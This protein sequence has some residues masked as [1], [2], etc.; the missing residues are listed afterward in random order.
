MK[1]KAFSLI[2]VLLSIALMAIFSGAIFSLFYASSFSVQSKIN[3]EEAI[4]Y[5]KE[6]L[7]IV[8]SFSYDNYLNLVSGTYV[9]EKDA[10][11]NYFLVTPGTEVLDSFYERQVV[12]SDVY[13]N[14]NGNIDPL[15]QTL[16]PLTKK[17]TI[18]LSWTAN[19]GEANKDVVLQEYITD[20]SGTSWTQTTQS[21]FN[22]GVLSDVEILPSGVIIPDDG[23]A[24]LFKTATNLDY[25]GSANVWS[26]SNDV[27]YANDILYAAV[28]RF[29]G[30]I[31]ATD[32]SDPENPVVLDCENIFGRGQALLV[33]GNYAYLAKNFFHGLAVIDISDPNNLHEVTTISVGGPAKGIDIQGNYLYLS[34]ANSH[35]PLVVVNISNPE[36]PFVASTSG[37]NSAGKGIKVNDRY[38]YLTNRSDELRIY[39]INNPNSLVFKSS[40]G[41]QGSGYTSAYK[42]SYLYIATDNSS[43]GLEVV[44]VADPENPLA[45]NT[46]DVG[47]EGRG[48]AI[49]FD[50]LSI[51]VNKT[52]AGAAV[53]DISDPL[54]LTLLKT[55]D[56]NG[57]GLGTYA[58]ESYF[59]EA[60]DTGHQGVAIISIGDFEYEL[61]GDYISQAHDT[62]DNTTLYKSISWVATT[63][64][65]TDIFFQIRTADTLENL[66]TATFVGPDGTN[67]TNYSSP[68]SQITLDPANTGQRF[69]QWKAYFESDSN[70][71]PSLDE[72]TINYE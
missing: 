7:E 3:Q 11:S 5:A 57:K 64:P 32:V 46:Y 60:V 29:Y 26:H 45:I 37:G 36:A 27:F 30:G 19:S 23:K 68:Y 10:N 25:F 15:G 33:E 22:T 1:K 49:S 58:T 48:A 66:D 12:I 38:A 34:V 53:Y 72:V 40:L 18:Q 63:P 13:R 67:T 59:Y 50:I 65:G 47:G 55:I 71:T 8:K 61:L 20:W 62:N 54:N 24:E 39:D 51:A 4:N 17:I 44:N 16:D 70:S 42:D 28:D 69:F 41:L 6:G 31:C 43:Q 14:E 9:L 35:N 2:E 56:I 21:Q 52:H